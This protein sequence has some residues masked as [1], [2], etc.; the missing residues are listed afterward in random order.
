[1]IGDKIILKDYVTITE[2]LCDAYDSF[3]TPEKIVRNNSNIIFL[4]LKAVAKGFEIINNVCFLLQNKF[5]PLFCTDD[6]LVSVANIVGTKR[7]KGYCTGLEI[8]IKNTGEETAIFKR[9]VYEYRISDDALFSFEVLEDTTV[10]SLKTISFIA[11]SKKKGSIPVKATSPIELTSTVQIDSVF[12]VSCKDNRRLQG[13]EDETVSEFRTRLNQNGASHDILSELREELANLPYI[14]DCQLFFNDT[15]DTVVNEDIQV[16]P[17]HLCIFLSGNIK[18]EIASIVAHKV[19]YPTVK[20]DTSTTVT[21]DSVSLASGSYDVHI[22][23]FKKYAYKINVQYSTDDLYIAEETAK[24][25][26]KDAVLLHL[27]SQY[28]VDL[29]TEKEVYNALQDASNSSITILN[30]DLLN[31]EGLEVPYIKVPINRIAEIEDVITER[32]V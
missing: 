7:R 12:E 21:Y 25:K 29:I 20:T 28:H 17:F 6:D 15:V 1:M 18:K 27:S 26:I 10:E 2:Q 14:F 30:V 3:I 9:G 13:K 5:N 24:E 8:L 23:P 4:L 19:F 31:S 11:F 32:V 22:I 16:K